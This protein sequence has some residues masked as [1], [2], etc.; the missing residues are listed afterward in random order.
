M[1]RTVAFWDAIVTRAP[2]VLVGPQGSAESIVPGPGSDI[3]SM[4]IK[5]RYGCLV[6]RLSSVLHGYFT[7]IRTQMLR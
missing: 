7:I 2:N 4:T 6:E 1:G 3:A 5:V